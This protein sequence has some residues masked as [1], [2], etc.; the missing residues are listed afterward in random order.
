MTHSPVQ[1]RS[2]D[3]RSA[4]FR[5]HVFYIHGFD[6]R[7]APIYHGHFRSGL[8]AASRRWRRR[9]AVREEPEEAVAAGAWTVDALSEANG[10]R[11]ET[12]YEML[13]WTDIVSRYWFP[14]R[15]VR[16]AVESFRFAL[17]TWRRGI[18]KRFHR[19]AWA[20][21]VAILMTP[22]LVLLGVL[23]GLVTVAVTVA[24]VSVAASSL[25]A[26]AGLS[27]AAAILASVAMLVVLAMGWNRLKAWLNIWWVT[28]FL[29]YL[30][31]M[32]DGAFERS[33]ERAEAFAERMFE[34]WRQGEV[35]EILVVGHSLGAIYLVR[36]GARL[37]RRI[38]HE[39]QDDPP[40]ARTGPR[41][42]LLTLGH[43]VPLY[44]L[45]GGDAGFRRDL[46]D[47]A[48]SDRLLVLDVTS[49]SDPGSSC[50]IPLV[51]G[52]DF[53]DR[54]SRVISREPDFHDIL[55]PE[56]FRRIRMRPLDFHF[57][58]LKP[59]ERGHGFDYFELVTRPRPIETSVAQP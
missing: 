11:V 33:E 42:V 37:L 10:R 24:A 55:E 40:E 39:A 35:D 31:G 53:G 30:R 12:R 9:I 44:T 52:V 1:D 23:V 6:P 58:Y 48:A 47:I 57:Q 7:G 13:V 59:S 19:P 51:E 21:Y 27:T 38:S 5:R 15:Q 4:D 8:D 36:A 54:S 56:T 45:L 22:A 29:G 18:L 43:T 3:G 28:R 14:R 49:G 41:I 32:A 46:A 20:L 26:T 2:L 34:V 17:A 16:L 50:R 25:G